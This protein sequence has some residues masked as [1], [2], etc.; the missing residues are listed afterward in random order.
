MKPLQLEEGIKHLADLVRG[1][2]AEAKIDQE[3]FNKE[4]GVGVVVTDEEIT[5]KLQKIYDEFAGQIAEL[6]AAFE[7]S[8]IIYKARDVLKWAD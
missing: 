7:F 5:E 6:G 3:E 8:K 1:K 4:A 2:G